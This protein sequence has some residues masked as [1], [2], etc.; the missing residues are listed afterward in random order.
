M[1]QNGTFPNAIE[2]RFAGSSGLLIENNLTDGAIQA[3]DGATATVAGNLTNA[4][5][6]FFV[7]APS[8]DLHLLPTAPALDAGLVMADCPADWDGEARPYAAGRDVGADEWTGFRDVPPA[9]PFHDF[10]DAIARNGIT[11]GCGG[12]NFCPDASVTR[13]EMA[14]FLLKSKLGRNHVP[15]PATGTVFGDV[16]ANDFAAAW[17]EE[18]AALGVTAGCGGGNYCPDAPV[19]RGEM[20]V[21]LLK[22]F[23]G[24]AYAPPP[25][26]HIFGDVP[27]TYF[28]ID[29]IEDLYNRQITGGC[30]ANPLRY[31]PE[32]PNTRGQMAVFLAKTFA[33]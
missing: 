11:V 9:H 26:Q 7:D 12:N 21:F 29:W 31:C 8:G 24:S 14:V 17:I 27:A 19:L 2:Y 18:L 5:A 33:F 3:R 10:V 20:A 15:P 13:A 1:I 4:T 23:L 16:A 28:A 25:A 22:A 6:D 30:L 32:D